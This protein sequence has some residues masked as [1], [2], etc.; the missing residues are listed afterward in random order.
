MTKLGASENASRTSLANPKLDPEEGCD[1]GGA[2]NEDI[3]DMD[4]IL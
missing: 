4:C 2:V 3:Q 1:A